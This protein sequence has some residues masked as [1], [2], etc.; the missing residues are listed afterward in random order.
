[1]NMKIRVL[2]LTAGDILLFLLSI[3]V[4][5]L[6]RRPAHLSFHYYL[7]TLEFFIPIL[8]LWLICFYVLALNEAKRISNTTFLVQDTIIS[9]IVNTIGA[10][11][12]FY[13]LSAYLE[14]T[15]RLMLGLVVFLFHFFTFA[16]RRLWIVFFVRKVLVE[17][18]AFCG[19]NEIIDRI[20]NE[21]KTNE[22]LGY[23]L[24]KTKNIKKLIEKTENS[25]NPN[26]SID[27][28]VVDIDYLDKN[29]DTKNA[30]MTLAGKRDLPILSHLS[31]YE[32]LY[33]KVPPEETIL[34][35]WIF[36]HI[37]TKRNNV[38]IL[39]KPKL[40]LFFGV[41][42]LFA[43]FIPFLIIFLLLA[44]FQKGFPIYTQ[45]RIGHLGKEFN[46]YKFRTMR[47]DAD[48]AGPLYETNGKD[49]RV[50]FIGK[51]LR[52]FRLDEIP[53]IINII[54][55]EMSLVGPRPEWE[56]E[57]DILRKELPQYNLR[58]M[59][60]PGVTGWA[61]VNFKATSS[62]RESEEKLRYDLYYVKNISLG[63]DIRIVLRTIRRIFVPEHAFK[64]K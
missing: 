30:I 42:L 48:T 61:Q 46:I 37:F 32:E 3:L 18:I 52:K 58:H 6:I 29:P 14:S 64:R 5:I 28:L 27:M 22:H 49:K 53:Q 55:G 19:S 25:K 38:Y 54:K 33:C 63:L 39:L 4:A 17:K 62:A 51:I 41:L 36:D 44:I 2:L 45:K 26:I 34:S 21:I 16:W 24:F 31:F 35:T 50:T 43:F 10:T 20:I 1:M 11:L 7:E 40:D 56:K 13:I 47:I 60:L 12:V 59:V 15:P 23:R 57:V 9:V 8:P